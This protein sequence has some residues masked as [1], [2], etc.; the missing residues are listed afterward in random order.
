[1]TTT[2]VRTPF[3]VSAVELSSGGLFRKQIL[4]FREIDYTDK[5]GKTRKITFDSEYGRNLIDAFQ[6]RAYDQVTF[7]LADADNRHTN[8][9]TRTGGEVVG[10][11]LSAD[12]SGV[13][14]ILRLWGDGYR[15][16]EANPKLGVSARML[17][18]LTKGGRHF[19][20]ALQHVLGTV[21]PQLSGMRPWE[22]VDSVELSTGPV[23]EF[24]DLS[25][26]TY[27]RSA[28]MPERTGGESE[29]V[30]L[31]LSAARAARLTEL[32]DED[33]ALA[34]LADQL[35]ALG[36]NLDD[37]DE[38]D[39]DDE[40]DDEEDENEEEPVTG[41]AIQLANAQMDSLNGRVVELTNQLNQQRTANEVAEFQRRG[42]S[43]AVLEMAQPLL[44]VSPGV[45]ELSNGVAAD[46]VDPGT[47]IRE[48]LNTVIELAESGH[49]MTDLD[50]ER[51]DLRGTNPEASER[52]GLL[53]DWENYG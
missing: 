30:T 22:K 23:P 37:V 3:S 28:N 40:E 48:V 47:V 19:P 38:L 51:G 24:V 35:T 31:E 14:G 13:D 50:D 49:L 32:L 36:I 7:Q 11:E 21:D 20:V 45:V 25:D 26:S 9:P 46:N 43:P 6:K 18:N 29:T 5:F 8:D 33:E 12:G 44:A 41:E 52:A 17:E 39:D 4:E 42:L 10:V 53:K 27:E 1:M 34:E 2:E 16:V 15:V